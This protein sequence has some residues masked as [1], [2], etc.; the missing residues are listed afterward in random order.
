M[1]G[2]VARARACL[3]RK[4]HC[5]GPFTPLR[6]SKQDDLMPRYAELV[7][8]G[9]WFSPEREA[10]Q[11]AIDKT[12]E[13]VTGTVRGEPAFARAFAAATTLMTAAPRPA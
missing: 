5:S 6:L 2:A 8:N 11:A 3:V 1:Q 7:Y 10:M 9:F 13:F 4:A 12:Q